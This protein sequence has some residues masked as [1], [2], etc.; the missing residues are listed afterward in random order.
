MWVNSRE[1]KGPGIE[2][3]DLLVFDTKLAPQENAF[4]LYWLDDDYSLRRMTKTVDGISLV[5]PNPEIAA[6]HVC[7]GET[8]QRVGVLTHRLKR[9]ANYHQHY[10]NYPVDAMHYVEKGMDYNRY[11]LGDGE[12]WETIFYLRV[13]GESMTGD[14]IVKDD[15]L[16]VDRLADAYED[17]I[18]VFIIDNYFTLKRVRH[19]RDYTELVAS[20]PL[21]P[22]IHVDKDAK[23]ES[24]GV[25]VG[26]VTDYLKNKYETLYSL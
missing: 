13:D 16:V 26:T 2:F 24:W 6:I 4:C 10:G 20:N 15:L 22:V 12:Y 11:F 19:Q 14:G 5:S 8:I 21:F 3:G 9:F 25:L 23:L 1:L 18:R 7:E 17:S